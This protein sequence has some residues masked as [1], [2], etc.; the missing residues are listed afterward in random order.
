VIF[1]NRQGMI[2]TPPGRLR[3][4]DNIKLILPNITPVQ[5]VQR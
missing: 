1:E 5:K 4:I 3:N 2:D